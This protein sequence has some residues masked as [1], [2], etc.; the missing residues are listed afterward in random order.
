MVIILSAGIEH[1]YNPLEIKEKWRHLIEQPGLYIVFDADEN[2]FDTASHWV[3]FTN[4]FL[5]LY[6]AIPEERTPSYEDVWKEG[7]PSHYYPTH[8]PEVFPDFDSYEKLADEM[9]HRFAPNHKGEAMHGTERIVSI[10]QMYEYLASVGT[11]LGTLTARP[12]TAVVK[13]A[14][15]QQFR[16]AEIPVLD[17]IYKPVEVPLKDSS[18][19]KLRIL[20][21]VLIDDS[22]STAKII[23]DYNSTRGNNRPIIQILNTSGVLTKPAIEK[24]GFTAQLQDGI[25]I[26]QS[27]DDLP[28]VIEEINSWINSLN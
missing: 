20:Q 14:T 2:K 18:I 25:F 19:E 21:P 3:D 22:V 27:W 8:F 24:N 12:A 16:N 10:K 17:V 23:K 13:R 26:M 1:G 5:R 15:E 11:I 6:A 9:R 28:N 4:R 7:G